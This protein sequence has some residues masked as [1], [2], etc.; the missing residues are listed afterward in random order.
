MFLFEV[1]CRWVGEELVTFLLA[2]FNHKEVSN[3]T[4]NGRS[5]EAHFRPGWTMNFVSIDVGEGGERKRRKTG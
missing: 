5:G 2:P 1:W 3:T 4:A